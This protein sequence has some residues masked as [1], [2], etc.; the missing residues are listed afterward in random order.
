MRLSPRNGAFWSSRVDQLLLTGRLDA[1]QQLLDDRRQRPADDPVLLA[2]Q[3][4]IV[5]AFR[6]PSATNRR[7]V[8]DA[9][10]NDARADGSATLDCALW[11]A[12]LD[13][14]EAAFPLLEGFYLG[15]GYWGGRRDARAP[16]HPLFGL[17]MAKL[18]PTPRFAALVEAIGLE[19][20]WRNTGTRPDFRI[21]T[22]G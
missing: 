20:Y 11:L 2:R 5:A 16:T 9:V 14:P 15:R 21:S 18:A 1:A 12:M 22:P 19:A 6:D 4:R 13:Q 8:G 3:S 17:A 10:L 7:S